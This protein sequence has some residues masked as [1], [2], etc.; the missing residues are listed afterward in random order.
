MPLAD[1][2]WLQD[3][4][5]PGKGFRS[6]LV[7]RALQNELR[8]ASV[9][10]N[11]LG[12]FA[13]R[14]RVSARD[15]P[16]PPP[17]DPMDAPLEDQV[18]AAV[19]E[20]VAVLETLPHTPEVHARRSVLFRGLASLLGSAGDIDLDTV[21]ARL[22]KDIYL[23]D[24]E[25]LRRVLSLATDPRSV[26]ER[27]L[28]GL[29]REGAAPDVCQAMEAALS[30]GCSDPECCLHAA[31][32][33]DGSGVQ[34]PDPSIGE[35]L[36]ILQMHRCCLV[37]ETLS[38]RSLLRTFPSLV[39]VPMGRLQR[40]IEEVQATMSRLEDLAS[41]DD[42]IRRA[43]HRFRHQP[44]FIIRSEPGDAEALNGILSGIDDTVSFDC[45]LGAQLR[46]HSGRVWCHVRCRKPVHWGASP[47]SSAAEGP[48]Q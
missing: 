4:L 13:D 9:K 31:T 20:A 48:R 26:E 23:R 17:G 16:P 35:V 27:L 25:P 8:A 42:A 2:D 39:D 32:L 46:W 44:L 14:R 24:L 21:D 45:P 3:T 33:L 36:A 30:S 38:M 10:L 12:L 47:L 37:G 1:R 19:V 28:D 29:Q 43:L 15:L 40:R 7:A 41:R 18:A 11:D 22:P 34:L 6:R 5:M